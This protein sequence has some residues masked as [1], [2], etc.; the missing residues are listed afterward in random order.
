MFCNKRHFIFQCVT[1]SRRYYLLFYFASAWTVTSPCCEFENHP[2]HS[3][4]SI[5]SSFFAF[6]M[7]PPCFLLS[8]WLL[9]E[10]RSPQKTK[11]GKHNACKQASSPRR[12]RIKEGWK[13]RQ[14]VV[15]ALAPSLSFSPLTRRSLCLVSSD[16]AGAGRAVHSAS[17]PLRQWMQHPSPFN[18]RQHNVAERREGGV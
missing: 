2:S 9:C 7:K 6:W 4:C 16:K 1:C 11:C 5:F 3:D 13:A 12:R 17:R 18:S 10:P 15:A 14:G 8:G